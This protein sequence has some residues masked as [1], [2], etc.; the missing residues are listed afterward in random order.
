MS[1]TQIIPC[2]ELPNLPPMKITLPFGIE[3][4]AVADFSKGPPSNCTLIQSLMVQ[5]APALA[6]MA[7]IFKMLNVF[8]QLSKM[9][10]VKTPLD[11]VSGIVNVAEAA[12]ALSEC[13]AF[14]LQIIC[15]IVG[16]LNMIIS[17]L[18]CIIEAVESLLKFRLGIDFS[19]TAGNPTLLAT[20]TC[21]QNNADASG[22]QLR[23]ALLLIEP[24]L[25]VIQ[26]ILGMAPS[27]PGPINDVIKAIPNAIASIRVALDGGSA[28]VGVP[29]AAG[30]LQILE[31]VRADLSQLQALLAA[32][33]C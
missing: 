17:F 15:M 8:V 24:L 33:P 20:L 5:L 14:P 13:F 25:I 12:A 10:S 26:P 7:C 3:L 32:I 2:I 6:G 22:A 18:L 19:L 30:P 28:S 16:I 31:S 21:A 29:G 11:V 9:A 4:N 23:Q 27:A 1:N